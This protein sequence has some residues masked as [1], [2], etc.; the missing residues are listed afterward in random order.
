MS[1]RSLPI[2]F[3]FDAGATS[4][5]AAVVN[6]ECEVM[7]YGEGEG[8]SVSRSGPTQVAVTIMELWQP[9]M[10]QVRGIWDLFLQ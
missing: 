3:A 8:A 4:T 7:W 9:S 2:V 1:G 6:S 5:R 10:R